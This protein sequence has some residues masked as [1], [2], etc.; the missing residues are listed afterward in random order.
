MS[1]VL[2]TLKKQIQSIR[3]QLDFNDRY[4]IL[5]SIHVFEWVLR[6]V[7]HFVKVNE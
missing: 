6:G 4:K 2:V 1:D 5:L 7:K 3:I